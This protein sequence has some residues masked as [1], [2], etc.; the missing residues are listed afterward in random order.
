MDDIRQYIEQYAPAKR[1]KKISLSRPGLHVKC[2]DPRH[3]IHIRNAT[4]KH[5][6]LNYTLRCP[7]GE[8]AQ[9]EATAVVDTMVKRIVVLR[10]IGKEERL[11]PKDVGVRM[12]VDTGSKEYLRSRDEAVGKFAA[13]KLRKG[14]AI[15]YYQLHPE[16]LVRKRHNVKMV[17]EKGAVHIELMGL[18]LQNGTKGEEVKVKNVS[19][20]KILHCKV[21]GA[22][23]V[24]CVQ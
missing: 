2:K 22:K 23:T 18:A 16:Y 9:L 14:K 5:L 24:G 13:Q 4:R 6:Y 7:S 1:I 10:T 15:K 12:D 20:G 19:S 21:I 3:L 11:G 8:T 17:Y